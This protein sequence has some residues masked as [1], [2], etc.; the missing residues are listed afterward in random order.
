MTIDLTGG[1]DEDW[2]F[3]FPRQPDD[4]EAR[5]SVNA[6]IWDDSG[7][8]GLP[9]IGVEAVADQWDTHDIQVNLGFADGRVYNVFGPGPVHDP[10][11]PD[12]RA[13]VLGAGPLSFE[14]VEPYRHLRLRLDGTAVATTSEAQINGWTPWSGGEQVP[15]R[16]E[17][18]LHP[19]APPWENGSTSDEARHILATQEE[20]DLIGYPWRFEQLCRASGTITIGDETHQI[21]GGADRIRRQGIRRLAKFWGHVWQAA[22]FPSGRGFG[23]Q[24][25]PPRADGKTTYNEGYVVDGGELIPARV[26]RAP[27][28]RTLQASGQDVTVVLETA[29]G[30]IEVAGETVLSTF[31]VMPPEVGGGMQLQQG[32][33]RY[34]WDGESAI[35]MIERSSTPDQMA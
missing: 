11:G 6:W 16:A 15:I 9:R 31:M 14:L 21:N 35:G 13:R 3:V 2:E 10:A 25:Y 19:A 33:A 30:T 32:L 20:G 34:T 22:L 17:I 24:V 12:G 28:L 29:K 8:F 7:T 4:P 5:E 27:W 26:V 18:D 23:F 1:L